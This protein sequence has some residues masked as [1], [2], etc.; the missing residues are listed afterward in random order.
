VGPGI[1]VLLPKGT[2]VYNI[3]VDYVRELYRKYGY[4]E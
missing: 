4:Q 2:T 3:L 1:S